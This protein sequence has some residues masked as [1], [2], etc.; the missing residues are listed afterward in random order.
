VLAQF[1]FMVFALF[2]L[3]SLVI[4]V[5]YARLTQAQ[6]QQAAD[7]AALEGLRQR[8]VG[9]VNPVNGQ[10]VNDPFASDC[11]R[12]TAANR[13]AHWVN[14]DDLDPANGDPD[15]QFGGGP[16]IDVSEGVTNL[17]ALATIGAP[18]AHSY[19]PDLQLNQLN[20][21]Y[22]DMVSGRFCYTT[23]PAPSEGEVY[24]ETLVCEDEPQRGGGAYARNDF[25]PNLTSPQPPAALPSCPAPDLPAPSPWPI[26]GTGTLATVN[27]SAFLVRL[28]RSNERRDLP[29]QVEEGIAS[30]GPALP[31]VF[32]RGTL[33]HGDS[34]TSEY[35]PRRDG[36]TIRATA[37]AEIRP[38]MRVGLPQP[39]TPGLTPFVVLD[40][41]LGVLA[42]GVPT[43]AV[44]IN[45]ATGVITRPL[46]PGPPGPP[47]PCAPGSVVGQFVA[48]A[49][50]FRTVG[51]PQPVAPVAIP[52]LS[53]AA[54]SFTGRYGPVYSDM[55]VG[56]NRIIGFARITFVR[57]ATCPV[58]PAAPFAAT[59]TRLPSA[60]APANATAM[61]AGGFPAGV[62]PALVDELVDKNLATIY[63]PV[64]VAVLAR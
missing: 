49:A 2:A 1:A 10:V 21:V 40:T 24:A 12:R 4:D 36:F 13:F 53:P 52:C 35:S 14:D 47:G 32:G 23:D 42:A 30:S 50:P 55:S 7:S 51:V 19:K 11:L 9:V 54:A 63:A 22:G 45:P 15:F 33:I 31:L 62:P 41:C 38:A 18:E 46:A 20:E 58:N 37:I 44:T 57:V 27:D 8:D 34:F 60:V 26:G 43:M 56:P 17:H 5:G 25:N 64:L 61:L 59:L 28:R 48:N 6:M 3:L 39:S 16:V 29:D